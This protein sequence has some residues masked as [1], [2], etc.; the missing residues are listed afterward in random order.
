MKSRI[1][2]AAVTL[3]AA[4]LVG[5][6]CDRGDTAAPPT[7]TAGAAA[8]APTDE[9]LATYVQAKYQA[10]AAVAAHDID[11]AARDGVVTLRGEV[12]SDAA[13]GRAETLARQTEGVRSV[14]NLLTVDPRPNPAETMASA[15]PIEGAPN[16]TTPAADDRR[17]T[18]A[19]VTTKIQ[20][21]YFIDDDVKPWNIDVTTRSDG[22][23]TLRGEVDDAAAR[24]AA[25]RIARTTE[26][27]TRVDNQLRIQSDTARAAASD[28]DPLQIEDAWLTAQ[29]QAKYFMDDDVKGRE[30][31][32]DTQAGAVTLRGQVETAAERRQAVAIA[33]NT[34]GVRSV[35]DQLQVRP[36]SSEPSSS[37]TA[38][39][40]AT[41]SRQPV[42]DAWITTKVQSQFFLDGDIKGRD[43]NVD[44]REGVVT[45]NGSV[46][47]AAE[48]QMAETIARETEGVTRVVNDLAVTARDRQ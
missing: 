36:A 26:G 16:A 37:D 43:I 44:T 40:Q 2:I 7:P 47:T 48:K 28:S 41:A 33:R 30:I 34:E 15:R 6:G 10:D 18:P 42:E 25:E 31:D 9:Q 24:E 29:I 22:S 8:H 19:W 35:N 21:Q 39:T 3:A 5:S 17:R 38:E 27:V 4:T 20:A 14:E 45:L 11:V 13:R 1:H 46:E 23:V 32:V 12:N